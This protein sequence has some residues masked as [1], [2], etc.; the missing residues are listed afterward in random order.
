MTWAHAGVTYTLEGRHLRAVGPEAGEELHVWIVG[1]AQRVAAILEQ[2]PDDKLRAIAAESLLE[3]SPTR[4]AA[5]QLGGLLRAT[6]QVEEY[7]RTLATAG[8]LGTLARLG[9]AVARLARG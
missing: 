8:R 7:G 1:D 6:R 3:K 5:V 4:P 2:M 9:K